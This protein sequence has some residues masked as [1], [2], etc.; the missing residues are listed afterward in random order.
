[1][2]VDP[3]IKVSVIAWDVGHNA[4]ARAYVL[5]DVLR[6][7]YDVEVIG[8]SFP[9]FGKEVWQPLRTCS[10]VTIKSFPG[11]N[12]PRHLDCME[13][14]AG[15]IEGDV[16]FVSKPRLPGI[17]LAILAKLHRN[18]PVILDMDDYEPGFFKKRQPLTLDTVKTHRR[19]LDFNRPYGEIWTRYSELLIPLFDQVT[20]SN[21]ELRKKFGGII[22]PHIRDEAD[23]NPMNY[24]RDTIRAQLGFTREDRV[25]LF[26]GTPLKHKGFTRVAAALRGFSYPNYKLLFI[27]SP[28]NRGS[29]SFFKRIDTAR[30][31]VVPNVPFCDLPGY[32]RAGDL[33]CLL[34]TADQVT[35]HF[36]M[37]AKFTDA[38]AMG[39]PVLASNVPPLKNL[40]DEGLVELLDNMPLDQKIDHIFC[41]YDLYKGKAMENREVFLRKYSYGAN[42]PS[43]K[44]MISRLL[45][46]STSIPNEFREL[47]AYHR[48]IFSNVSCL[49]WIRAK[50]V[51][52]RPP[53]TTLRPVE[54]VT[55]P[56]P[57]S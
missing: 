45:R 25:I 35:S 3:S 29:R 44:N 52:S 34:P 57:T 32:L 7:A 6:N 47:I 5:A 2:S 54:E 12:F 21:E 23:F 26:A 1:M 19:K 33:I 16:L 17:E 9:R 30:T 20:V 4:V 8:T 46:S 36:Q 56:R 10:R 43:L 31:N 28:V 50:S 37:P 24:S 18:R 49:P 11:S 15:Q 39:I 38:L 41:N 53:I 42:L 27:G 14:I 55:A 48:K 51:V 40:A 22:L 13:D